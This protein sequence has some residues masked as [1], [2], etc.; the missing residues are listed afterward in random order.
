MI[1]CFQVLVS[2]STR[3]TLRLGG[4]VHIG[5]VQIDAQHRGTAGREGVPSVHFQPISSFAFSFKCA[6]TA[7]EALRS[8]RR[9]ADGAHPAVVAGQCRLNPIE[10]RVECFSAC[11]SSNM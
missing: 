9:A 4:F 11:N 1:N 6:A 8:G 5:R 3:T 2:H 7:C 10:I